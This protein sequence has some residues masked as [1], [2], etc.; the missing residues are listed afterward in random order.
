MYVG[1]IVHSYNCMKHETTGCTPFYFTFGREPRLPIDLAFELDFNNKKQPLTKYI[2]NIR[3]RIKKSYEMAST[4]A[5][6]SQ[7]RQKEGY[8]IKARGA[9]LQPGDRVLVKIVA[10]DGKHKLADKWEE[11]IYRVSTPN[12][13]CH[14]K[15]E[16]VSKFYT[17]IYDVIYH[18]NSN[19][20]PQLKL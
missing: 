11:D 13:I 10:Y 17:E 16:P 15:N 14:N 5:K 4:A 9:I 3:D 18:W 20:L 8:D 7:D 1:T 2:E 19:F 12:E 6:T